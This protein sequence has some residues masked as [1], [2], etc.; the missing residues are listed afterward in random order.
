[1]INYC[2][3]N[4]INTFLF[5]SVMFTLSLTFCSPKRLILRSFLTPFNNFTSIPEST[6]P[7]GKHTLR[8]HFPAGARLRFQR[9]KR[10]AE[11]ALLANDNAPGGKEKRSNHFDLNSS[12]K[13]T[14]TTFLQ[15]VLTHFIFF[16]SSAISELSLYDSC[17]YASLCDWRGSG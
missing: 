13:T 11:T 8:I 9:C 3:H 12:I 1:M 5:V 15:N 14:I 4:L 7:I 17:N 16:D 6:L 10:C 2:T